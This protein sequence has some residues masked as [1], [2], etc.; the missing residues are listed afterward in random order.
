MIPSR[1]RQTPAGDVSARHPLSASQT[2]RSAFFVSDKAKERSHVRSTRAGDPKRTGEKPEVLHSCPMKE[3]QTAKRKHEET[4]GG[5]RKSSVE[6]ARWSASTCWRS[7][8]DRREARR[9]SLLSDE[10]ATDREAEARGNIGRPTEI[11]RRRREM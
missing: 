8:E 2:Q 6:D 10:G 4:L 7:E 5:Q 3:R 9:A 1:Y 11:E